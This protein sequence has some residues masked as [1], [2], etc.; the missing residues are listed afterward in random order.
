MIYEVDFWGTKRKLPL[1]PVNGDLYIAAFNMLGDNELTELLAEE[2]YKRIENIDFD[3]IVTAECKGIAFAQGV[4]RL[5]FE[6]KGQSFFVVARKGFKLY[7]NDPVS[8]GV[9]SITTEKEQRLWLSGDEADKLKGKRV[10]I[11]DDVISTGNTVDAVRILLEKAGAVTVA[12][13]CVFAEGAAVNRK[14]IIYLKE[15][16][17]FDKCGKLLA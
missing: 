10:I 13:L 6:R 4:S 12:E 14:D 16:P 15:L 1:C 17:L 3:L 11:A 5:L 8:V 7:M 9:N 2:A